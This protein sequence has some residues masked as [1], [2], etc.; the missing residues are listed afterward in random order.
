MKKHT[1]GQ[2]LFG[3]A[4]PKIEGGWYEPRTGKYGVYL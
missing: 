4:I 2:V 3:E 1:V